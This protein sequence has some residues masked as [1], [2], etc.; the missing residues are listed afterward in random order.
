MSRSVWSDSAKIAEFKILDSEISTDVLIVGGGLCGV[1]CAYFMQQAGVDY[2]LVEAD[3]I[4]QGTTKNSTAKI[5]SQHGLVY[6]KIVKSYGI[7]QASMVLRANEK[8]VL[9]YE[10]LCKGIDC[11]YEHKS[12][13]TYSLKDREKIEEEIKTLHTMGFDAEFKENLKLPFKV[14][15]AV[16]FKNQAQF[17]PVKFI[18]EMAKDLNIYEM[19]FIR[20]L[21]SHTAISDKGKIHAKKIIVAT[22]FPFI[23]KHGGY[24]VKLYQHR[25]YVLALENAPD[26]DGMYVDEDRKGMSFRNGQNML[27]VGGGGH[28]TGKQGGSWGEL[29]S[30]VKRN[31]PEAEEKYAW[32]AQDCMSLDSI[33]YIGLY[34]KNTPDLYVASG[35]NKWGISSSMVAAEILCDMVMGKKN[36]FAEVFSPQRSI[37]K[38]QFFVNGVEAVTNLLTPTFK[39]CPHLGCALKWNRYEHTWDCPCHGSRFSENGDL[40][41]NPATGGIGHF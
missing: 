14:A 5:T 20:E 6:R 41:D 8:A 2:V 26:V 25:S 13:Y 34:S 32:A 28:R 12:A 33:P 21:S 27:F 18:A 15:G 29:R 1:L 35:F 24:F 19:T 9:K 30:F 31:L 3:R 23:N 39:R 4:G 10:E 40:I 7:E 38:P 17:N 22:H 36:E 37:I 11:E 16:E